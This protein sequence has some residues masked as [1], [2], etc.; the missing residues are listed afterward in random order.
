[1]R[2]LIVIGAGGHGKIVADAAREMAVWDQIKFVDTRFPKL[3][4]CGQWL[5]VASNIDSLLD[6]HPQAE[7][8]V[9]VGDNQARLRLFE[10]AIDSGFI[11]VCVIHP[12]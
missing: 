11:P 2:C 7:F 5:V 10:S 1:M 12:F 9:A 8:V 4:S 6:A 3:E